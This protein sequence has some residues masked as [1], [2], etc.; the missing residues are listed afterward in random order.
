MSDSR[1]DEPTSTTD[2]PSETGRDGSGR[3][4][5][6]G[7][8]NDD[9]AYLEDMPPAQVDEDAVTANDAEADAES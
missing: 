7:D 2:D 1:A 6:T 4:N 9:R 5:G 3:D 8:P